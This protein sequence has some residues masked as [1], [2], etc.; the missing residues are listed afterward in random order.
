MKICL[1]LLNNYSFCNCML[2]QLEDNHHTINSIN[3]EKDNYINNP[4]E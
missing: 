3:K 2:I 1:L 4:K